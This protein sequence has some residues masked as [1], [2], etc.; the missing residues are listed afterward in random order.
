MAGIEGGDGSMLGRF[1]EH[2]DSTKGVCSQ[3]PSVRLELC[4]ET[5][6]YS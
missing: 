3:L 4:C 1:G 6:G 2:K 5:M